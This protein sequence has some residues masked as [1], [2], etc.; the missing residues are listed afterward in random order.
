MEKKAWPYMAG[1]MD[2]EGSISLSISRKSS[3]YECFNLMIQVTNTDRRLM[4]WMVS[5]FGGV[6][7]AE[8]KRNSFYPGSKVFRWSVYGREKQ[9]AFLLGLIPHLV[10]KKQQAIKGLDFLRLGRGDNQKRRD[11]WKQM[12]YLNSIDVVIPDILPKPNSNE[13][14]SYVAGYID[15]DGTICGTYHRSMNISI[16]STDFVIIKWLLANFG[17]KFYTRTRTNERP[18]FKKISKPIHQW[19]LSG[20]KNKE[21]FLLRTIP[22][23]MLKKEQA[24][25]LLEIL[26]LRKQD[27]FG[28]NPDVIKEI[29][30][31]NNRIRELNADPV[32]DSATTDT[33]SV[34]E[35]SVIKT[36]S[37]LTGDSKSALVETQEA[38]N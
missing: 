15:G 33:L 6:F 36:Q 20:A 38:V 12:K 19:F 5:N 2:S 1:I 11:L 27:L 30:R 25:L 4:D 13:A 26:R 35:T 8:I 24:K 34:T 17:G 22:Y 32:R 16:V 3:G 18:D 23:M 10:I 28:K 29:D 7:C 14:S 31:R 21:L 9:E 37:E